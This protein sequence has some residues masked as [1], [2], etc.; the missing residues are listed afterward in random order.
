MEVKLLIS[1]ETSFH[2]N[3]IQI[4]VSFKIKKIYISKMLFDIQIFETII[5][6]KLNEFRGEM[7]KD[8]ICFEVII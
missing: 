5:K 1:I 8:F 6:F 4:Y 2:E 7:I 3:F